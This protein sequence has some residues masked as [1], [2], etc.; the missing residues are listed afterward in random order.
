MLLLLLLLAQLFTV[1]RR[2]SAPNC[3]RLTHISHVE[4]SLLLLKTQTFIIA[5]IIVFILAK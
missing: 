4:T 2:L 5:F 3:M 1:I